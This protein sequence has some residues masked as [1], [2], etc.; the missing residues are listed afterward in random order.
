MF[1]RTEVVLVNLFN[2]AKKA[3]PVIQDPLNPQVYVDHCTLMDFAKSTG[4]ESAVRNMWTTG[5]NPDAVF[6]GY[7]DDGINQRVEIIHNTESRD[8]V[9]ES[10]TLAFYAKRLPRTFVGQYEV[11]NRIPRKEPT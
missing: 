4:C 9:F 11:P 1:Q 5:K 2:G 10:D 3:V 7:I 6:I 8:H